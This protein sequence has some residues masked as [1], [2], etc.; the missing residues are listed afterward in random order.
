MTECIVIVGV[1]R[2]RGCLSVCVCV[3]LC[4]CLFALEHRNY[5]ADFT[6]TLQ[7]WSLVGLVVRVCVSAH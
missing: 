6:Q 4:V 5:W 2:Y 7:E 3:R 1:G